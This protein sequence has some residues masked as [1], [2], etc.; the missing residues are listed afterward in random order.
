MI[1]EEIRNIKETKRDLR[2]FGLTVGVGLLI[3]AG[4]LFW[5]E[6]ES[7]LYFGIIGLF[8]VLTGLIIPAVLKPL[9]KVWMTLAILMGW[10]MTRVILTILYYLVLTPIRILAMLFGKFFLDLNIDKS[11]KSYWEIRKKSELKPLDYERQF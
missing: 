6:K 5:K 3:F 2:K 4:F 9:N 8:L 7:F 11:A 10:V 1:A